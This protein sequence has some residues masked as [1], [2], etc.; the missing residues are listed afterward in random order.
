MRIAKGLGILIAIGALMVVALGR[1]GVLDSQN[2]VRVTGVYSDM[3]YSEQSGDM[4]GTEIIIVASE[5]GLHAMVQ[6]G[7]GPLGCPVLVPVVE[8]DLAIEFTLPRDQCIFGVLAGGRFLGVVT[9]E[10]LRGHFEG[11]DDFVFEL[12]RGQSYWQ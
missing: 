8:N 6:G 1:S 5:F 11:Y 2:P 4:R 3:Y 9:A 12:P 10:G 7:E